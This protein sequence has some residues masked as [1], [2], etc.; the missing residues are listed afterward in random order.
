M[1]DSIGRAMQYLDLPS[2]AEDLHGHHLRL[3]GICSATRLEWEI[4]AIACN[5]YNVVLV[6]M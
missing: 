5:M 2:D 3:I 4:V 6:P 1:V